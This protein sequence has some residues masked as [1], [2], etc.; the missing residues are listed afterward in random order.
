[1]KALPAWKEEGLQIEHLQTAL[2]AR[3]KYRTVS[4]PAELTS[5]AAAVKAASAISKPAA[6][7]TVDRHGIPESW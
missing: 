6:P 4:S 3:R 1:M 5:D 7:V 2:D